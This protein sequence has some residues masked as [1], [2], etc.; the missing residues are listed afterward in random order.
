MYQYGAGLQNPNFLAQQG[1]YGQPA[2]TGAGGTELPSIN[3][4]MFMNY[5]QMGGG[6]GGASGSSALSSLGP[7]AAIAAAIGVSKAAEANQG[8]S[9]LGKLLGS[10]N[11]PSLNQIKEDPKLGLTTALGIPFVN[12]LIRNDAAANARPEW[13]SL[14]GF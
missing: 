4:M 8:N 6:A 10:L 14:L 11:A 7:I 5:G 1:Y 9:D 13:E 2:Q 12:G 3:P